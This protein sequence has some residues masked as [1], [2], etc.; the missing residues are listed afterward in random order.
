M[1]RERIE[2]AYS[3]K[4]RLPSGRTCF[5]NRPEPETM[6]LRMTR[7]EVKLVRPIIV[8]HTGKS[9]LTREYGFYDE[10]R[11]L[12]TCYRMTRQGGVVRYDNT[13]AST[14]TIEPGVK[15]IRA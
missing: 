4:D 11:K 7:D 12:W 14:V 13:D 2:S 3:V 5:N 10:K 1:E 6:R 8:A 15:D 9:E